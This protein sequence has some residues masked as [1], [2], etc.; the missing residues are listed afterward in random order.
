[1]IM[2]QGD[3]DHGHDH[4]SRRQDHGHK[5]T[6][7]MGQGDQDHGMIMGQHLDLGHD[8]GHV[9]GQDFFAGEDDSTASSIAA[10]QTKTDPAL[11]AIKELVERLGPLGRT[12]VNQKVSKTV[13]LFL[14]RKLT[15]PA[16]SEV[17]VMVDI[18]SGGVGD[19]P[20]VGTCFHS[21]LGRTNL[22]SI[23]LTQVTLNP[24]INCPVVSPQPA[25]RKHFML[26][27]D[28]SDTGIRAILSQVQDDRDHGSLVWIKTSKNQR[29]S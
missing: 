10:V 13:G 15:I 29:G 11:E 5:E 7:I 3:Q 20:V 18:A 14:Q 24:S 23:T 9:L 19:N 6:K 27:T 25:A 8:L 26:D 1:M 28:A 17:K 22:T 4:G 2:G 12:Y 16:E 21:D